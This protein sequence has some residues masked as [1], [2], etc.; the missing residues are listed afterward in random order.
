MSTFILKIIALLAMTFDH[1]GTYLPSISPPYF[2]M[3]GR[4]AG[5]IFLFCFAN[6]ME[7]TT[8]RHKLL[9]RIYIA[10]LI[11]SIGN[12]I[13]IYYF[14]SDLYIIGNF[15]PT[16]FVI[17]ITILVF[18]KDYLSKRRKYFT[19]IA[20]VLL[21]NIIGTLILLPF[22]QDLVQGTNLNLITSKIL[23]I[24]GFLPNYI[25][26]E[27]GILWVVLG[28]LFYVFRDS[29]HRLTR[30]HREKQLKMSCQALHNAPPNRT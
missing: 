27:S 25:T 18:E 20:F 28:L 22:I 12:L 3:L 2:K 13:V 16:L 14:K 21:Q 11:T 24:T 5:P 26:C 15:F 23:A 17:G 1:V 9:S 30:A 8:S 19:I 6:S 29:K 7:Y 10:S 4:L